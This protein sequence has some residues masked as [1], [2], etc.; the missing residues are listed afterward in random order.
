[1]VNFLKAGE[2][3]NVVNQLMNTFSS[4][5]KVKCTVAW[6]LK[7]KALLSDLCQK[8]KELERIFNPPTGSH[9]GGVWERLI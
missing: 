1:M 3:T 9:H 2:D 8:R 6:F 7:L 4:W 5:T